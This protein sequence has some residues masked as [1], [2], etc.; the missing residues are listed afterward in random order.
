M[1]RIVLV[2]LSTLLLLMG[3]GSLTQATVGV[4]L[5]AGASVLAIYARMAQASHHRD[6]L[7]KAI[8]E[9]RP[10]VAAGGP[11]LRPPA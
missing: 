7:L 2:L 1:I 8:A 3:L 9:A 4:G 5:V 10:Q 11:E 6:Q